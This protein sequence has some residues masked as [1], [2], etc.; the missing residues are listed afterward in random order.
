MQCP[1]CGSENT[2]KLKVIFENG[3]KEINTTGYT[4]GTGIGS[5]LGIGGA[6]TKTTG[7]S[8]SLMGQRTAPPV[9]KSF[10]WAAISMIVGILM[11]SSIWLCLVLVLGGAAF[12]SIAWKY[13]TNEW[14]ELY[15]RW[16]DSWHCNKCGDIYLQA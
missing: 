15:R 4:A 6:A 1:K 11:H 5:V 3:T 12:A 9:K 2:Q 13:N 8:Q 14:P 16:L 10:K 7:T